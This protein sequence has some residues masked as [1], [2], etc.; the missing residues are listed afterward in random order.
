MGIDEK[1]TVAIVRGNLTPSEARRGVAYLLLSVIAAGTT[2]EFPRTRIE[3]SHDSRIAFVDPAPLANYGHP[4]RY[5]LIR[6]DSGEVTSFEARFPPFGAGR[7][8][9]RLV[10]RAPGV[11]DKVL[12]A[13][14]LHGLEDYR[15]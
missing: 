8:D 14:E 10:H 13:P 7:N 9:W 11:P 1:R 3:A 15:S 6:V 4:C 12:Q 5:L 2:L